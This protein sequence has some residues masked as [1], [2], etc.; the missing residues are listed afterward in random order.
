MLWFNPC[1]T[2]ICQ[3]VFTYPIMG[4]RAK[5]YQLSLS[6]LKE[7]ALL[8]RLLLLFT[9]LWTNIRDTEGPRP[10]VHYTFLKVFNSYVNQ[11]EQYI[12]WF[13]II[14]SKHYTALHKEIW[15]INLYY[16]KTKNSFLSMIPFYLK[17]P[18]MLVH[19]TFN[20]S[21]GFKS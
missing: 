8:I 11:I 6:T 19:D 15:Q 10:I 14:E 7:P 21:N 9:K 20:N 3:M 17:R 4:S 1:C 5:T 12:C 16:F 2:T 13:Y 18:Y